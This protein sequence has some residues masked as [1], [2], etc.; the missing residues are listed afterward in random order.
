MKIGF[1]IAPAAG[2]LNPAIALARQLSARGHD[3]VFFGIVDIASTVEKSGLDFIAFAEHECPPGWLKVRTT[4]VSHLAGDDAIRF[5]M[6]VLADCMEISIRH[7]PASIDA[8]CVEGLVLDST[9]YY[10]GLIGLALRIPFVHFSP[11]LPLDLSGNTPPRFFDWPYGSDDASLARNREGADVVRSY[12]RPCRAVAEAYAQRVGLSLDLQDDS[13]TIS[14]LAWF[15]PMPREIDFPGEHWPKQFHYTGPFIDAEARVEVPFPWEALT[16]EPVI[17]ASMG[18]LQNGTMS[19]F[20][21]IIDAAEN[22]PGNQLVL[23]VGSVIDVAQLSPRRRSTIVVQQAPQLQL[24]ERASLCVTHAGMNTTLECLAAGVPTVALP[25]ANDQP[26]VAARLSHH[27]C[28]VVLPV[29]DVTT[30]SLAAVI[31]EVADDPTYRDR[32]GW[33]SSRIQATRGLALAADIVEDKL[34][35]ARAQR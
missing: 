16:G 3:V 29:Q 11:G 32:A 21:S 31:A 25:V 15:T 26:A 27:G 23:S 17:Y 7:M 14:E 6:S 35:G 34:A 13:H 24:L 10:S 9:L 18:T 30:P 20:Q 22:R 5:S 19:I 1:L 4:G 2:H 33:F 12:L 28:G 8:A